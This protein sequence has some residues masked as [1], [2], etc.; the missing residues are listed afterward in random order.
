AQPHPS[1]PN[2][3]TGLAKDGSFGLSRISA[4]ILPPNSGVSAR[5]GRLE[6]LDDPDRLALGEVQVFSGAENLAPQGSASQATTEK[7]DAASLAIDG[8]LR[9]ASQ[10]AFQEKDPWWELDLGET[11]PVHQILI[12]E[13]DF[14]RPAKDNS[15]G[16]ARVILLDQDRREVASKKIIG[17]Q[18]L[19]TGPIEIAFNGVV[20]VKFA[21][22]RAGAL[23]RNSKTSGLIAGQRLDR[24]YWTI[25]QA[26]DERGLLL[27]TDAPIDA[28]P[29]SRIL[30][31]LMHLAKKGSMGR[32]SLEATGG[33][34]ALARIRLDPEIEDILDA[35]EQ[36]RSSS[37][38][39]H[40]AEAYYDSVK[41]VKKISDTWRRTRDALR[42]KYATQ[43]TYVQPSEFLQAFG[44]PARKSPCAC[45]RSGDATVS[46]L[47]QLLNGRTVQGHV[48][49]A[50]ARY[51]RMKDPV[52]GLYLAAFSR[53]P[54]DAER[55]KA[56]GY[57]RQ[58]DGG[59]EALADL[60]WAAVNT[61]EFMFQH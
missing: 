21:A 18:T 12:W 25:G 24:E 46:Q 35:P 16:E 2:G 7:K 17:Y 60:I 38:R 6:M 48:A 40:L 11:K 32:F 61:K 36:D 42:K 23:E 5:Y 8:N 19:P 15:K 56:E 51:S 9:K 43:Q 53:R 34:S 4:A 3:R 28:P 13:I 26:K 29:G 22:L 14:G 20:P 59:A 27:A 41:E 49:R 31:H 55:A 57:L 47:L 44:Q 10:T 33:K 1:L 52:G 58:R 54:T 50:V 45:E 39:E 37:A 30:L